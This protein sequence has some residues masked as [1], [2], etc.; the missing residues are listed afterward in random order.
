M[1]MI[2][3]REKYWTISLRKTIKR[4]CVI[5]RRHKAKRMECEAPPLPPDRVHD[6]TVFE[7][8]GIDFAGW[9]EGMDLHLHV[10][11]VPSDTL[12]ISIDV[13]HA[14]FYRMLSQIYSKTRTPEYDI[15]Q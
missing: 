12:K 14:R 4:S 6:A 9:R 3:I 15:Q 11:S 10:C 1:V 7:I 2:H 8:I 5:C 13:I